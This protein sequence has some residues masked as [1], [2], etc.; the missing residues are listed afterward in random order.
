MPNTH[1]VVD[2]A[3]VLVSLLI[4]LARARR[5]SPPA[6][7]AAITPGAGGAQTERDGRAGRTR[8][9]GVLR[10]RTARRAR[11]PAAAGAAVQPGDQ[12]AAV[13]PRGGSLTGAPA[14]RCTR[15]PSLPS[16]AWAASEAIGETVMVERDVQIA[17]HEGDA[18]APLPHLA[19]P[20]RW[21]RSGGAKE[22]GVAVT[23][24]V[25]PHHLCPD[26]TGG[27]D[28]LDPATSK[29]NPPLRGGLRSG[30]ADRGAGTT[31]SSTARDRPRPPPRRG[32]E[33]EPFEAAPNGVIGLEA[34]RSALSTHLVAPGLVSLRHPVE[35]MS[36][37][38]ARPSG[39]DGAG[40]CG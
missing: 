24:E 20:S 29:M 5:S 2:S 28:G 23:A 39:C 33:E 21:P 1:P 19:P 38:P 12:P 16:A 7:I 14:A 31:P 17:R 30:G 8:S 13:A 26:T 9:G 35:R 40:H 3:P 18:A 32:G 37:G 4:G 22:P 36:G 25:S 6:S 11:R 10:R 27:R 15:E 34:Q